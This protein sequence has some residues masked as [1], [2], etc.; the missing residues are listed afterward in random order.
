MIGNL[1]DVYEVM[2]KIHYQISGKT[3]T[4]AEGD[5]LVYRLKKKLEGL[6]FK[7]GT[8][9]ARVIDVDE[10][11]AFQVNPSLVEGNFQILKWSVVDKNP[12]DAE[13]VYNFNNVIKAKL[14]SLLVPISIL[15]NGVILAVTNVEYR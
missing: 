11:F 5:P 9:S 7:E 3:V 13:R 8:I 12:N 14:A 6:T 15:E 2:M 10:P 1:L 4:P